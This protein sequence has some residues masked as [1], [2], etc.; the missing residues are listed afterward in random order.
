[1]TTTAERPRQ[2]GFTLIEVMVALLILALGMV[3]VNAQLGGY[4]TTAQHIEQKTLASWVAANKL[5]EL[6]V[7]SQWPEL[8]DD[9]E[10]IDF[11]GRTW[12]C[13][14]EV[15][16][17][18]VPN[19]RRVDVYVSFAETPDDVIHTMMG[20]IE[21]PPPPGVVPVNWMPAAAGAG[22]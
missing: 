19:L 10:E 18:P 12:Q 11:A 3:A 21:P 5:T 20:L 9:E 13:R 14:V 7:Q 6:S 16:E 22:G 2:A 15:T 1:M 8:G 17:T 4:V